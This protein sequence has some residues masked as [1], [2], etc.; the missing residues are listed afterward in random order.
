MP[1]KFQFRLT[2]DSATT[3]FTAIYSTDYL[4]REIMA[5]WSPS[6]I[7]QSAWYSSFLTFHLWCPRFDSYPLPY[8][9][10]VTSPYLIVW[11][12][13]SCTVSS[14]RFLPVAL[15]EYGCQCLF[16][17]VGFLQNYPKNNPTKLQV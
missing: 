4:C 3:V 9:N 8:V 2:D 15:R 14:V 10:R 13:L 7:E 5:P 12:F 1:I 11:N 17:C 6:H 16:D